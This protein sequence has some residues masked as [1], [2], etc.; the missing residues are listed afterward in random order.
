MARLD[1]AINCNRLLVFSNELLSSKSALD[2]V[3]HSA[4]KTQRRLVMLSDATHEQESS[5]KEKCHQPITA[6]GDLVTSHEFARGNPNVVVFRRYLLDLGVV[7]AKVG[8]PFRN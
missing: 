8:I 1:Q 6:E 4:T 3:F 2:S 5:A 7:K